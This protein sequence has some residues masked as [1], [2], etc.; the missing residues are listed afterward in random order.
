MSCMYVMRSTGFLLSAKPFR[1]PL[2]SLSSLSVFGILTFSHSSSRHT[3]KKTVNLQFESDG[4][5]EP[6]WDAWECCLHIANTGSK[7][8][9]D[10]GRV[11][12]VNAWGKG[13]DVVRDR[14]GEGYAEVGTGWVCEWGV[15]TTRA[16]SVR[17]VDI[18][19]FQIEDMDETCW[20]QVERIA[21]LC[22]HT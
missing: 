9:K 18:G 21:S 4:S 8:V 16:E 14:G 2:S 20:L 3:N 12:V 1:F 7:Q 13:D 15:V 11:A 5:G 10:G 6:S 17:V 22:S 19:G